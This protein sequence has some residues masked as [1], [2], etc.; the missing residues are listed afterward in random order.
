MSLDVCA[1]DLFVSWSRGR[2]CSFFFFKQKTAYEMR[3]SDWSSD[4]C[5]SDLRSNP[6]RTARSLDSRARRTP[7]VPSPSAR[8]GGTISAPRTG[9]DSGTGA[10]RPQK[11]PAS[12]RPRPPHS[13]PA[14]KTQAS[15]DGTTHAPARPEYDA[16]GKECG[17]KGQ[18]RV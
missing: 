11:I 13:G 10:G 1:P 9:G 8:G 7:P 16:E 6:A 14:G 12:A 15:T 3:I 18:T 17:R 2:C 4:V 5:S